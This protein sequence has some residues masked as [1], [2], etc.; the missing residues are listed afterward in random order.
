MI[1]L[2]FYAR[3][4][5]HWANTR[6]GLV[7]QPTPLAAR[8]SIRPNP[9]C[10]S[11]KRPVSLLTDTT[12]SPFHIYHSM[13]SRW[14]STATIIPIYHFRYVAIYLSIDST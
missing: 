2:F 8:D 9:D 6:Q 7:V 11:I 4:T 12:L 3:R 13:I 10:T 14:H 5:H 1:I